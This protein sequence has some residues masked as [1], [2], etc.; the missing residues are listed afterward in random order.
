LETD[1]LVIGSG[2]AG[3]R[4][5]LELS[6]HARV[7]LATKEQPTE[8]ATAYAQGGIAVALAEDDSTELHLEDTLAAGAGIVSPTAARLL[9]EEGTDRVRE[10]VAWGARFDRTAGRHHFTREAAHSRSRVLHALGDATGWEIVRALLGR[11]QAAER[12]DVRASAWATALE[13]SEGR[14]V[15]CRFVTPEVSGSEMLVRARA[16]LL[17]TGGASQVFAETTNPAVVTGD[18]MALAFRAGAALAD[19]EFV[20]FHPTALA[21]GAEPLFLIS[22]AVR[23]EGGLLRNAAGERFTEELRPRDQVARAIFREQRAGRGPV[24]L[25]VRHLDE[26]RIRTRF[27]RIF[28]RCRQHGFDMTKDLVPV[29]PAAHY[30]MGGVLTDLEGRTTLQGLYAAGEAAATGVQ[31]ANRLASNSLLEG[32]GGC[33]RRAGGDGPRPAREMARAVP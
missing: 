24:S 16:T 22:E 27:P 23:G 19:L 15:G 9:V 28:A 18:G 29:T 2:V 8:S 21:A 4:A 30:V 11:L 13:L 25:D 1:F 7:V 5:A 32:L 14:V 26:E 12:I 31:G 3:L 6:Q 10:L 20:Q 33:G 17:A